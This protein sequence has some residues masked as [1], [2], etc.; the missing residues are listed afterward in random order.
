M[1]QN[2]ESENEKTRG[3]V[4]GDCL[5]RVSR[6]LIVA[7]R[8]D[9]DEVAQGG[10]EPG[11][12]GVHRCEELGAINHGLYGWYRRRVAS[13]ENAGILHSVQDDNA[14]LMKLPQC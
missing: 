8:L 1:E 11:R 14:K 9:E 5:T 7:G 3:N 12:L 6:G 13:E 2:N 4:A 10:G